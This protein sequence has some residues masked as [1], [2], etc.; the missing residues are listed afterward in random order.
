MG[1]TTNGPGRG[2]GS[3][4]TRI[5]IEQIRHERL[6]QISQEGWTVE[7]DDKWTGGELSRAAASYAG[8]VQAKKPPQWPWPLGWWKPKNKR[9]NLIRAAAL[10]VA[11]IER[12]D[13]QKVKDGD[14]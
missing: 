8:W 6:R 9:Q 2:L 13:R 1:Q 12:L 4:E 5:V 10:I 14:E 7:H 3:P 11:E